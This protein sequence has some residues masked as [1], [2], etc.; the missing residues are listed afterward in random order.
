MPRYGVLN[1]AYLGSWLQRDEPGGP[2]WALNL[3]K[4]RP[5][6]DYRDGRETSLSGIEADDVYSPAVDR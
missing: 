3:M 6:A 1:D 2:M 4:Y 5:V